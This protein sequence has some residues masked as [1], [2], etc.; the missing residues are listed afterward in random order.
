MDERSGS[1]EPRTYEAQASDEVV[2][3]QSLGN[4]AS[5]AEPGGENSAGDTN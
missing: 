4:K 5:D 1:K 2:Q 3:A